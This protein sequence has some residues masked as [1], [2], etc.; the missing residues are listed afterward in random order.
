[1]SH[2][3]ENLLMD[4]QEILHLYTT[5]K[6]TVASLKKIEGLT[7]ENLDSII[8]LDE[9]IDFFYHLVITLN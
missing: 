1:M 5:A 3:Q 2:L 6:H 9:I 8:F 4:T 7:T